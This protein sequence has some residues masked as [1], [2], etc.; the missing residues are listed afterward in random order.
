MRQRRLSVADIWVGRCAGNPYG[1]EMKSLTG[2]NV[3]P[4][5]LDLAGATQAAVKYRSSD[6]GLAASWT[7]PTSTR[8]TTPTSYYDQGSL[9]AAHSVRSDHRTVLS[10]L[11][12]AWPEGAGHRELYGPGTCLLSTIRIG[13]KKFTASYTTF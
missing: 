6:P 9:I 3:V 7:D 1:G 4:G 11:C 12:T 8:L 5:L 13:V 2:R 10:A